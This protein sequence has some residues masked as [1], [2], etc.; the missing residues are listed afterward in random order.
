MVLTQQDIDE[1]VD[2]YSDFQL[3]YGTCSVVTPIPS[4]R[5]TVRFYRWLA[6]N[7][8]V[9]VAAHFHEFV[10]AHTMPL[11]KDLVSRRQ[12]IKGH[13][14]AFRQYAGQWILISDI[15]TNRN[16]HWDGYSLEKL[17]AF[18]G[19]YESAAFSRLMDFEAVV[20]LPSVAEIIVSAQKYVGNPLADP[21]LFVSP[22]LW[23]PYSQAR[24]K[25]MLQ[26]AA[27]EIIGEL[28]QQKIELKA[29]K[30]QTFEEIVAEV[31]RAQGMEIHIVRE[32]PQGG[33]DIIARG[34]LIPGVEPVTIAVEVKHREVVDRP[35]IQQ[36]LHQNR[37]FPALLFVTSGRFTAGVIDES[38][39]PENR[40]RLFLK[41]GL[42]IRE[43][44]GSLK[45]NRDPH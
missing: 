8:Q 12:L 14:P 9:V 15:D 17:R 24:E 43:L 23:T 22:K 20:E 27:H 32:N 2:E 35:L 5:S 26:K 1:F 41:D 11:Y 3:D 7:P 37:H 33:R 21:T 44:I 19:N 39:S 6:N 45:V 42:A 18:D 10:G 29:I 4:D 38:R 31:L 28:Q 40:M 34:Q 16:G 36:A 13:R 25:N 30:W